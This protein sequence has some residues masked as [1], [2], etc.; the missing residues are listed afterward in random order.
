MLPTFADLV[1]DFWQEVNQVHVIS[2]LDE[3]MVGG[4]NGPQLIP[5]KTLGRSHGHSNDSTKGKLAIIEGT[6]VIVLCIW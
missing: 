2:N 1:V 3:V 6:P 4:R 5:V